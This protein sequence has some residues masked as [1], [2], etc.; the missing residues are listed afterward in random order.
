MIAGS[1]CEPAATDRNDPISLPLPHCPV[2]ATDHSDL[3]ESSFFKERRAPALPTPAEIRAV[4]KKLGDSRATDFDRPSPVMFPSLGMIVKY[5][6]NVT[7]VEAQTQMVVYKH[8]KGQVPVPEVFEWTEDQRFIY[9][10]LIEGETL[11]ER[12]SG[13]DED[14][15]QDVC[16]ELKHMAKAWRSLQEDRYDSSIGKQPLNEI[17]LG[18]HSNLAG[19][20]EG[21]NAV[22]QFQDGCG[23]EIKEEV[24]IVFTHD[25]FVSPDILLTPGPNPKV[26]AV[27]DWGQAGWYPAYWEYC[28]ARRVKLNPELFNDAIQEEWHMK[29]LPLILDPMDNE[30]IYFPWLYFVLSK[31]I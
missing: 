18:S 21:P 24:P 25:D 20:L 9:M 8:L 3:P 22:Q 19:P 17:F 5:G 11:Q 28:K 13:M 12:W 16:E 2:H 10:P 30:L 31:G 15:R 27:I 14:E 26:A 7:V 4:G 23:M 1:Q 29:Y 6:A